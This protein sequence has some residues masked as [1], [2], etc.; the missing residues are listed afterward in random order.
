[1]DNSAELADVEGALDSDLRW[2][3]TASQSR[4]SDKKAK[5]TPSDS[6]ATRPH[7]PSPV[8]SPFAFFR[9]D[10]RKCVDD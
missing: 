10:K 7:S 9:E 3:I 8:P 2:C 5:L 6:T 1:M 4:G